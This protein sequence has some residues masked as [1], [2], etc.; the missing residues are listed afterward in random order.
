LVVG[1]PTLQEEQL[2]ERTSIG[3]FVRRHGC[4]IT[5]AT[6]VELQLRYGDLL[7]ALLIPAAVPPA[8]QSG[9]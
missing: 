4:R 6:P 5:S 1:Q 8:L 2:R 3:T 9:E 7:Y